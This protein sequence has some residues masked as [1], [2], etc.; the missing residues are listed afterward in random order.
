MERVAQQEW[1]TFSEWKM[2]QGDRRVVQLSGKEHF[3]RVRRLSYFIAT[4]CLLTSHNNNNIHVTQSSGNQ[5]LNTK[6]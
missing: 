1:S 4:T 6:T 2:F 3:I 5:Q